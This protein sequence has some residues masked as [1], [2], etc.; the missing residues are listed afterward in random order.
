MLSEW[1]LHNAFLIMSLLCS[2]AEEWKDWECVD[3]FKSLP[4]LSKAALENSCN[5]SGLLF[6]STKKSAACSRWL[7]CS[8]QLQNSILLGYSTNSFFCLPWNY[9]GLFPSNLISHSFLLNSIVQPN[10]TATYCPLYTL[11][12][13]NAFLL[14]LSPLYLGFLMSASIIHSQLLMY[15]SVTLS[16]RKVRTLL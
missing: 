13:F 8:F 14:I 3:W 6:F 15:T 1:L 12:Y 11:C 2:E 4:L 10:W 7:Y 5:L 16:F 9:L